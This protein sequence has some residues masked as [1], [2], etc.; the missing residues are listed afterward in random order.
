MRV[1]LVHN[2]YRIKGGEDVVFDDEY[3]RISNESDVIVDKYTFD[4]S[5]VKGIISKF[6]LLLGFIYSPFSVKGFEKKLHEFKPDIVHFH[7][8]FPYFTPSVYFSC[9]RFGVKIVQTVHN[10]RSFST[11]PSLKFKKLDA[12]RRQRLICFFDVFS[13]PYMEAFSF[14]LLLYFFVIFHSK[15]TKVFIRLIDKYIVMS[16]FSGKLLEDYVGVSSKKIHCKNNYIE[17]DVSS[18]YSLDLNDYSIF[19]GRLSVEKGVDFLIDFWPSDRILVF[20]GDYKGYE[21]LCH[22]KRFILL[23]KKTN[24][25]VRSLMKSANLLVFTSTVYETFGNV[26]IEAFSVGL[27][28]L[29]ADLPAQS[30]HIIPSVNGELYDVSSSLDFKNKLRKMLTNNKRYSRENIKNLFLEKYY[31]NSNIRELISMYHKLLM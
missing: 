9:K 6:C 16:S 14:S 4:S 17:L 1:L 26:I 13:K 8:I 10:Y 19:V 31:H 11:L 3:K 28:V 25:E 30:E 18:D 29:C 23:G 7:N 22:D 15:F 5:N 27:P 12:V 20:V 2:Y 24:S 21:F